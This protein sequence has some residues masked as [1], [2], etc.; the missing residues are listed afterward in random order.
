MNKTSSKNKQNMQHK[1]QVLYFNDTCGQISI[2]FLMGIVIFLFTLAFIIQFLPSL[3]TSVSGE[4]SLNS[5]AYRT[6]NILTEDPGWWGNGTYNSTDWE[7][8]TADLSRIGLA[9]DTTPETRGTHTPNMLNKTKIQQVLTLNQTMVTNK[10]GLYDKIGGFQVDYGYNITLEQNSNPMVI[11]GT[12]LTF[13]KTPPT[14]Q[15]IIKITRL[16]LAETYKLANYSA[17]ELTCWNL[18]NDKALLNISGPLNEEVVIQITNF[19]VTGPNAK[20]LDVKLDGN[21]K[22]IP[23]D[24]TLYKKTNISDFS[25]YSTPLTL[26]SSDTLRIIFNPTLFPVNATY[27]LE[28]NFNQMIFTDIGSPSEYTEK[29]KQQVEAATLVVKVWK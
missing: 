26:N 3:F 11:N 21:S 23:S 24:Y 2:D 29:A 5:V 14:S 25:A 27:E 12:I 17:D 7:K 1:H 28:L 16:V 20:L 4:G 15:D 6:A 13:G 10:L 22:S 19:N 8:H 18:A 9:V